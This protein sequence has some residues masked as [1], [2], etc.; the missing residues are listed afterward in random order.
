MRRLLPRSLFSRLVL[1]FLA[2]LVVAQGASLAIILQD[3]GELLSRAS[4]MQLAQR[5]ADTV[6][7]LDSFGPAERGRIVAVL[8]STSLRVSLEQTAPP[9]AA[10]P[11]AATV[12]LAAP[13]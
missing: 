11:P 4:G 9:D 5:I 12:P 7:L 3:R 8:G 13:A 10:P 1:V 2:G 6:D